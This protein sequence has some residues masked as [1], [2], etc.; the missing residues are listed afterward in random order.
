MRIVAATGGPQTT[1]AVAGAVWF[2]YRA[3][4]PAKVA[5]WAAHTR[6][7]LET[8]AD[9]PATGVD[10]LTGYEITRDEGV[11]PPAPW[12]AANIEVTRTPAPVTGA[13]LAW[14]FRAP[15]V[16]PSRFLPWLAARLRAP[17]EHRAVVD[18]AAE[19]GDLVINC[20]GLGAR[21]LAG[22]DRLYPLFG[23]IVITEPGR[24]RSRD[25]RHRRPRPRRDLLPDPAA[26]RARARRL[27]AA[28]AARR[29]GRD[30]SRAHPAHP[31][32]GPRARPADRWRPDRARRGCGRIASRSGSSAT[33]RDHPQLRSRRRGLHAVPRLRGGGRPAGRD[34]LTTAAPERAARLH[35]DGIAT[36]SLRARSRR[37]SRAR[38]T[39]HRARAARS[40]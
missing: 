40:G 9:D 5:A 8:L 1:S 4:P 24:G 37:R 18:L 6:T 19:P 31:R 13:P 34:A 39:H 27:L 23:Q 17:I 38:R 20:T 10:V 35:E 33:D 3:G 15:R 26:R 36:R 22:D 7:W 12:W 29:A 16:E 30:R 32:A 21:E 25:H 2:P 11:A 28:V 14:T